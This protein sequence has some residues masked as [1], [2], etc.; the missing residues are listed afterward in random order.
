M[1]R[2]DKIT[3]IADLHLA[4]LTDDDLERLR[5]AF[6]PLPKPDDLLAAVLAAIAARQGEREAG[7]LLLA[8]LAAI[9]ERLRERPAIPRRRYIPPASAQGSPPM[10]PQ[11]RGATLPA[12]QQQN[13]PAATT[14]PTAPSNVIYLPKMFHRGRAS[15]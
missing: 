1:N 10:S 5:R 9:H 15:A 4:T 3:S 2:P 11:E 6:T 7:A 8:K 13:A 14:A 12:D